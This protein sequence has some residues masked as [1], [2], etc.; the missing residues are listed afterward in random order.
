MNLSPVIV[1][2]RPAW[3][4][5]AYR[6]GRHPLPVPAYAPA[7]W[8]PAAPMPEPEPAATVPPEFAA[9]ANGHSGKPGPLTDADR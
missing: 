3:R 5:L 9:A 6:L 8:V 4:R 1:K 7:P 2:V